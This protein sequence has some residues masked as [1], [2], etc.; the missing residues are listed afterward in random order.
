MY[1][2]INT[3]HDIDYCS[4]RKDILHNLAKIKS[5]HYKAYIII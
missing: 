5:Y 3:V 2:A 1:Q 4:D